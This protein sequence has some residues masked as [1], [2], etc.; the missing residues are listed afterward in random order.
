MSFGPLSVNTT[1]KDPPSPT[2]P[3]PP[4]PAFSP[5]PSCLKTSPRLTQAS[6]ENLPS[7]L[8]V[9]VSTDE[10][11]PD[12]TI[13]EDTEE[14]KR[15]PAVTFDLSN[16]EVGRADAEEDDEA[17][18]RTAHEAAREADSK[19]HADDEKWPTALD[20]PLPVADP[21]ED[22]SLQSTLPAISMSYNM[23]CALLDRPEEMRHL[24]THNHTFFEHMA[25]VVQMPEAE[26]TELL[27]MDRGE[28]PDGAWM[29]RI[30]DALGD[31]AVSYLATF[32]DLVGYMDDP[33][34]YDDD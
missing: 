26:F 27:F 28:L 9:D 30:G 3:I 4:H 11:E 1:L 31:G 20:S 17:P 19:R 12:E 34:P 25:H 6:P 16:L 23:Q 32:K 22:I 24:Y 15:K 18:V 13:T 14:A 7:P 29:R 10:E 33:E 2:L 5:R 8:D 21:F